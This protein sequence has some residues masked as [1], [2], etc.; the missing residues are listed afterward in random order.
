MLFWVTIGV[1][2]FAVAAAI[3]NHQA[4]KRHHQRKLERIQK[5][6]AEKEKN[7]NV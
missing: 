4:D 1:F 7:K 2:G 3:L 5:R 6:L